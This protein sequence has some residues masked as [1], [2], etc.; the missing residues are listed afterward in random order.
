MRQQLLELFQ[1]GLDAVHGQL[2]V[3]EYLT[4]QV[5]IRS[6]CIVVAIGKAAQAMAMG[7]E[8]ALSD[9]LHKGLLI[10]KY[11]HSNPG[12]LSA[13]WHIIESAHPVPDQNSLEAG[14][15]LLDFLNHPEYQRHP[16]VFLLSG[17]SSSLVEVLPKEH[18]HDFLQ[19]V[20][21][22]LLSSG[23]AIHEINHV[24]KKISMIKGGKLLHHLAGRNIYALMISDVP[25]DH[26]HVIG[27][28]LLF[29]GTEQLPD[30]DLPGWLEIH[31]SDNKIEPL[32]PVASNVVHQVI[33]SN[34]KARQAIQ[35]AAGGMQNRVF[36]YEEMLQGDAAEK[37]RELAVYLANEAQ[38]GIHV[39]GGETTVTLPEKPGRGGRNQH[40]ALSAAIELKDN[41]H[42]TLLAAG[43][44]GTDGPTED[45]GAVVDGGTVSRGE[46]AGLEARVCLVNADSGSF[47]EAAGDLVSTGP[48]GTNVMD[49]VVAIKNG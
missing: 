40:L 49:L 18:D 22:W 43:T 37:G 6:Q 20:N 44:D 30:I 45:A 17:G 23:L 34:L 27:S 24:R 19:R 35:S 33:A 15:H 2:A 14:Q 7:C 9:K 11:Q 38:P 8:E 1:L 21:D 41:P 10:T 39:W 4:S 5:N 42:I 47:L 32:Y 3:R 48:T 36:L 31:V 26:P 16:V 46:L 28:G 25:G 12:H 13:K 29:P